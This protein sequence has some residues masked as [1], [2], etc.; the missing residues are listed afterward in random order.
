MTA[1]LR[2]VRIPD[3]ATL[4]EHEL[5]LGVVDIL[6]AALQPGDVI[7]LLGQPHRVDLLPPYEGPLVDDGTYPAGTR[8]AY[9]DGGRWGMTVPSTAYI[10]CLP[11]P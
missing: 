8:F 2:A 1:T 7:V 10:R 3:P 5:Q 11:R 6:G 4:T 9:A